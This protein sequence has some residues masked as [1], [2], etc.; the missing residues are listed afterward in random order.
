MTSPIDIRPDHLTTV[1]DVLRA[2]L[3]DGAQAWVFGSR[4]TWTTKDSS[5]LDLAVQANG[6]I[7][8]R[9]MGELEDAFR[10]SDLP[11]TVDVIDLA[12]VDGHFKQV[13][14]SQKVS[15][16]LGL[17][18]ADERSEWKRLPFS[19]AV[20]VNPRVHLERGAEYPYVDMASVDPKSRDIDVSKRRKYSGGGSRFQ[21]G[22]TLMARITP[23]LENGKIARYQSPNTSEK[24]AHGS[25]EF[26]VIRGR[27]D[28]TDTDFAYYL[29]WWEEV[30]NYAIGHMTG[31]SGRQRV[32]ADCL[33][34]LVVPIPP[35]A[36]QRR[37]A[38][39]L[40]TLDDKIDLNRRMNETLEEMARAIFTSWF[41]HYDPVRAKIDGRWRRGESLPGLPV[42]MYDLFPARMVESE[43]GEVPEGWEVRELGE[44]LS[45]IVSGQR[46]RGGAVESGVPSIGA[47][48]II[49][50]GRYNFTSEKYVPVD[51]FS[52]LKARGADVRNG[53]VLL[54]KDGAHIGRKTY[55]D[56]GFPH[57][58]CAVNEHVF[59]LRMQEPAAQR[60][61]FFWLDQPWMTQEIVT[62]NSNSAQPGINQTSVRGLPLLVPPTS[63]LAAFDRMAGAM[64]DRIFANCHESQTL[65][66]LRDTLLPRLVS[67]EMRVGGSR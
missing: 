33:D 14:E 62:L 57:S 31:T 6:K 42:D 56:H 51:F 26:I 21:S 19:K 40:G 37:I 5:D 55:F 18:G 28:V 36:Q 39:I 41:V 49:G 47:E 29:T 8:P 58:E 20:L 38:H 50:L 52:K 46:P 11:Y 23:C 15:L 3:P 10:E 4:A 17:D 32:P 64:T 34:D 65:G 67:G 25:T 16:P 66:A 1:L 27:P 24:A 2:H 44:C 7:A 48:N 53:D 22:D 13:V 59:I 60:Y 30:R 45:A 43:L 12:A 9:V 63:L 61:L 54:Y 35:L